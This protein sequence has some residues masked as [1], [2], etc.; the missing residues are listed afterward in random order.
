MNFILLVFSI[1]VFNTSAYCSEENQVVEAESAEINEAVDVV[2]A[3]FDLSA[4]GKRYIEDGKWEKTVSGA[5]K[6]VGTT[7]LSFGVADELLMKAYGVKNISEAYLIFWLEY[8]QK[9]PRLAM[10]FT[11]VG[12]AKHTKYA[13]LISE[14]DNVIKRARSSFPSL[15]AYVNRLVKF[16]GGSLF[17][18]LGLALESA[19]VGK[20]ST[21][22]EYYETKQGLI[23]VIQNGDRDSI[24]QEA[25]VFES[26]RLQILV[27]A[28]HIK[29]LGFD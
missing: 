24:L 9:F 29:A 1:I 25:L 3:Y 5:S 23:D 26:L 13:K 19:D 15:S 11:K 14:T 6:L 17:F 18:G 2:K 22:S 4:F 7:A 28:E 21:F 12:S 20:G 8:N 16:V 10:K 27:M